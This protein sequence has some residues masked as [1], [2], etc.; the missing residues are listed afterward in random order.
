MPCWRGDGSAVV[1]RARAVGGAADC[2]EVVVA[3]A[4]G[5]LGESD[6]R[7]GG[8]VLVACA[9]GRGGQ[10][11]AGAARCRGD[12]IVFNHADTLLSPAHLSAVASG[13][14]GAVGGAFYKALG[15]HHPAMGWTEP[16]VRWWTRRFGVL[17]GDQSVFVRREVFLEMGGFREIPLME[18]VDFSRRLRA[19]GE[20]RLLDPVLETSM[21]TFRER[22]YL[23][24]KLRNMVFVWAFQLGI[25]SPGTLYRWYYRKRTKDDG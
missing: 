22:G 11:N 21:R 25:A 14:G 3:D 19:A 1:E 9:P 17:Y 16:F 24:T 18:D 13:L 5:T 6:A 7:A 20:V 8:F 4:S 2:F 15:K 10:L 12:V 23:R